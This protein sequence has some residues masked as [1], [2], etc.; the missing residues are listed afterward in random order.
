MT[1]DSDRYP[2]GSLGLQESVREEW[3]F[4]PSEEDSAGAGVRPGGGEAPAAPRVRRSLAARHDQRVLL[5]A[6]VPA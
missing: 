5:R 3:A 2:L 4:L 6:A 1:D